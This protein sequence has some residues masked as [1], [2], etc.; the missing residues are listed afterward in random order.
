MRVGSG[1]LTYCMNVHPGE[2][3][4]DTLQALQGAT[5]GV[6]RAVA[7]GQP[8][9]VGLRIAG[10]AAGELQMPERLDELRKLLDESGMYAFTVN[11]FPY[12][13]FH[14]QPVKHAVYL[15][16]WSSDER[17]SYTLRIADVL[18][19][20][21]PHGVNGTISTVP[22]GYAVSAGAGLRLGVMIA[23]VQRVVLAL[24]ELEQRRGV[25]I[26]LALE[27]EPDCLLQTTAEV[28]DVFERYFYSASGLRDLGAHC[29]VSREAARDICA[30]HLGVCLDACHAAVEY[31]SAADVVALLRGRGITIAKIQLSSGLRVAGCGERERAALQRFDEPV[32]LHQVVV[33]RTNGTI[34]RYRDLGDALQL[35]PSLDSEWRVHFH[36][37]LHVAE[38][39]HLGSTRFFVEQLLALHR[40]QP[41]TEHLEVETYTW[42]VLPDR[43]S[44]IV[45]S[46]S[47]E[48]TW[49]QSQL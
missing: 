20:L 10:Q 28:I 25:R 48:L 46:I 31:E 44:S 35:E 43:P 16:D 39:S 15:P 38:Y 36:V 30:R 49:V 18:A 41:I 7:G 42:D 13:S 8:F 11:G 26:T 5:L 19:R 33:R 6:K 47:Q 27:P 14:G 1:H 40:L 37:P 2:S 17:V 45:E 9:G 32:Y 4:A 22:L 23:N 34:V 3:L 21:L 24:W 29:G 12:G